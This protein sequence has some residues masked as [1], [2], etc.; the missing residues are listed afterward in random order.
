MFDRALSRRIDRI[1]VAMDVARNPLRRAWL[2][3]RKRW[4]EREAPTC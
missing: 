2:Q 1:I 4:I 3:L